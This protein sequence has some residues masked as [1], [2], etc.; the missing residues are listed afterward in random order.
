MI[1]RLGMVGLVVGVL[2]GTLATEAIAQKSGPIILAH[3]GGS[4]EFEENTLAAFRASYERGI[5]GF[6]TDVRMTKDGVL[7][8][9]H[10][11]SLNRTHNCQGAVEHQ[12]AAELKGV[13]SKKGESFLFLDDLLAF[14]ADKPGCYLELEMKTSNKDLYPDSRIDEFCRKLVAAAQARKPSSSTYI[15]TSFDERPLRAVHAIAP[16][17]PMCLIEGK[18]AS[19]AFIQRAKS[20]G[21]DRIGCQLKGTSR[22]AVEE[23]HKAGLLVSVWPGHHV[24]DYYLA[25]GLG[26]D[27]HCTDIPTVI[28]GVKE[29]L[30]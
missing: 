14:F 20:I 8:I 29:T 18:P 15:F 13:T 24:R 30:P 17:A 21:A 7:V 22:T 10:D 4:H 6:E 9:L 1:R 11:D 3:R 23:A 12:T 19:A 27:V 16:K 28:Q 2:G 5:R 25:L 26:V